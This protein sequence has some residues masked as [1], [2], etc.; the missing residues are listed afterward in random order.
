MRWEKALKLDRLVA[1]FC[2]VDNGVILGTVVGD[3]PGVGAK[4]EDIV[5]CCIGDGA[6]PIVDV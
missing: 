5:G 4:V 1:D 3:A 6:G 2:Y